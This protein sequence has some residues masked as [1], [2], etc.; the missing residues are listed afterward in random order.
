MRKRVVLAFIFIVMVGTVSG[1][2]QTPLDIL[3]LEFPPYAYTEHDEIKGFAVELVREAFDRMNVAMEIRILPWARSIRYLQD[4]DADGLFAMIKT[5]ERE[6]F[7]DYP[8]NPLVYENRS[9][10][11][12]KDA[13]ISF[14]GNLREFKDFRIGDV[15]G[16]SHG[17][18]YDNAVK[19][20]ILTNID[21]TNS[22]EQNVKKLV[23]KRLDL[24]ISDK[25]IVW[26][27]LKQMNAQGMLKHV[28]DLEQIP[29]YLAFSKKR[30]LSG[31]IAQFDQALADMKADGTYDRII[32]EFFGQ[33]VSKTY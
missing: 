18:K 9:F 31:I 20:G 5:D 13:D 12:H 1:Q 27:L 21:Y 6:A 24:I 33:E 11:A 26:D 15:H 23:N 4:G 30:N 3:T 22:N 32:N 2:A 25:Y 8:E 28:Y 16:F 19:E 17:E 29:S 10:F 7:A 14:D